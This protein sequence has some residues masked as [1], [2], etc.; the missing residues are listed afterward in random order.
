MVFHIYDSSIGLGSYL[1]L[2]DISL[3]PRISKTM[4]TQTYQNEEW[5]PVKGYES[6]YQVSNMGRV[7]SIDKEIMVWNNGTHCKKKFKGR[8]ISIKPSRYVNVLLTHK[9]D[10]RRCSVHILV[11]EAFVPNPENKPQVNHLN[12]VKFDNRSCNLE[13]CTPQENILHART[14]GLYNESSINKMREK[15]IGRKHTTETKL[16]MRANSG[17]KKRTGA[18][19][20]ASKGFNVLINDVLH[21]P[22]SLSQ[23]GEMINTDRGSAYRIFK[24]KQKLYKVYEL[25]F[26]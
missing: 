12:G 22:E 14:T 17:M 25:K 10:E 9:G 21:S 16:K 23:F 1:L 18:L 26:I 24:N 6:S 20:H 7:R 8:L 19:H 15:Q 2:H 4:S 13:W 11:A 3:S 5:L